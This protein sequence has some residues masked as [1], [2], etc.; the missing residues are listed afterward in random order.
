MTNYNVNDDEVNIL[1]Q[2]I[3]K[4]YGYDFLQYSS[5]SVKRRINRLI[6]FD[7]FPSF[8]EF[9]YE[10]LKDE[11]YF[12]RFLQ[13]FTVNVTEMFRDPTF[14]N[15][16]RDKVLP[17]LATYP[18]I[19]IW[20]AGCS[21]GE[22]VYSMA[23]LLK[24]EGLLDRSL[25]YA[26]DINQSVIESAKSGIFPLQ[27]MK[28]NTENYLAAKGKSDFSDYYTAAYG[29]ALFDESLKKKMVFSIHNLVTDQS[30]NEFHL[31][32]CRNVLI[33]FNQELQNRAFCLFNE[34]LGNNG[35]LALGSKESL[36]FS[37]CKDKYVD[38]N[39]KEKI[40]KKK[41]V[42]NEG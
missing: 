3:K 23:I 38:V 12:E 6:D 42:L 18:H 31:I 9:R 36:M 1:L 26:T 22:E 25:I 19:K 11:N 7:H 13:E 29:N 30:F 4:K 41:A 5:A 39:K 17:Q 33:Y 40:W 16:L 28:L 8:A 20:H 10:I 2:D 37:S 21:T 14:Y 15:A 35:F 24:E 27:S 34:S 32:I